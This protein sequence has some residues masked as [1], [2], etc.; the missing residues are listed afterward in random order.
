MKAEFV[1]R[2]QEG[3]RI[4][5]LTPPRIRKAVRRAYVRA[6]TE[7]KVLR[8]AEEVFGKYGFHGATTALIA[9]HAGIPKANLHYYFKTKATLYQQLL[10]EIVTIWLEAAEPIRP[11]EKP[12]VALERYIRTKIE[13]SRLRPLASKLFANEIIN[14]APYLSRYL[15]GNLRVV[16]EE[17]A[18]VIESWIAQ[19]KMDPIDPKHLFYQIWAM[20]QTYA[21]FSEQ[22]AATLGKSRLTDADF[23]AAADS[24]V[25]LVLKGTGAK[26]VPE[27]AARRHGPEAAPKSRPGRLQRFK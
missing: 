18:K 20:T 10:E 5:N 11:S 23:Q 3:I 9:A 1:H 2:L 22:V 17:K 27:I 15:E 26:R 14:G 24:I 7:A 4:V 25:A 19:G 12:A 8:A 13:F 6:E 21:D 16:L